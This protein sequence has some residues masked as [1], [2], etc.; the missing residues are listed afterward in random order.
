MTR[1]D[2]RA[3]V[4]S[5]EM[6]GS[7]RVRQGPHVREFQPALQLQDGEQGLGCLAG[8]G[9]A[10]AVAGRG[11]ATAVARPCRPR[12]SPH[13]E[14]QRRPGCKEALQPK[15]EACETQLKLASGKDT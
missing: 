5:D 15:Q 13:C 10:T 12:R 9:Q 8:R 2:L 14:D 6:V 3:R 11:Q 7:V 4:V 1:A